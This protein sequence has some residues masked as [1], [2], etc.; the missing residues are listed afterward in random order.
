MHLEIVTPEQTLL[1][2]DVNS[3][4]LPGI[5]GE[6]QLLNSHAPIVSTL[7]EGHLKLEKGVE[8]SEKAK[9]VFNEEGNK[10]LLEIRGGVVES[11]DNKVIVLID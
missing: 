3:V 2:Q 8:L 9:A 6:F 10:L 4:T 1:S 7:A 5:T 11:K